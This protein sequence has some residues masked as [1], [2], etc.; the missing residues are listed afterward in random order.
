VL[1]GRYIVGPMYKISIAVALLVLFWQDCHA[2]GSSA[3][4][5]FEV[6]SVK[7]CPPDTPEPPGEHDGTLQLTFPGGRFEA[8]ATTVE[9][10]MEWAYDI[11]RPQHSA[12]PSWIGADRFQIVAKAGG[13]ASEDQLKQMARMLLADRFHLKVHHEPRELNAYVMSLG[14][15]PPKLSPPHDGESCAIHIVPQRIANQTTPIF[16]IVAT[17]Y[18][19]SRLAATFVR[20]MGTGTALVNQT[21]LDG[22][23]DFG[24]DLT[25]DDSHPNP[26]DPGVLL[27][28]LRDLGFTVKAQKTV[29]DFLVIDSLERPSG[30]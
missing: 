11:Q 26:L 9:Y 2:Q 25:T 27:A 10:L 30:N 12:D 16:H 22:D 21:G 6:A 4:P 8:D 14:K 20:H 19:L 1:P 13:N 23:F 5:T 28:G 24:L 3:Q 18:S 7:P 29:V 17:R 15:T